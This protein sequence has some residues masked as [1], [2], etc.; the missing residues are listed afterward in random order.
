[1]ARVIQ[2]REEREPRSTRRDDRH[3]HLGLTD[4]DVVDMYRMMLLARALDQKIWNLNRMGRANFVISGQGQEAAGVG[5]AWVIRRGHDVVLPYYRDFG[6]VLTL[7]MTPYE[8][9]LSVFARADDP[10]SAG[11]Q[12]PN[13]WGCRRLGIITGSSPIA[14]QIPHAAG[15]AA[16]SRSRGDDAVTFCY[17]GEGAASKGDFHEALNFAGIHRLP[18]VFVCEN[19]GYA[20]SV[21]LAKQSAVA[22]VADRAASYGF[23]GA[24]VDGND[25]LAVYQATADAVETARSGRG[26]TLIECKTYRY[27]PHTS[28]DDDRTYRTREEVEEA[29]RNDPI[30]RFGGELKELG[31]LD[32]EGVESTCVE[33][34]QQVDDA[35]ARAW[36]AP[37]PEP[38]SALL[39]LYAEDGSA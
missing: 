2:E 28:D 31:L 33:L 15:I 21:P 27:L 14:T 39:H 5:S 6:V 13:H 25:P 34:K 36:E 30:V 8:I 26:P 16:A 24:V 37:D 23:G 35:V 1:M 32:D 12:M 11:R 38:E 10:N 17:F 18:I 4:A 3:A 22:D 19:N 20:I 29:K 7:G 9:L